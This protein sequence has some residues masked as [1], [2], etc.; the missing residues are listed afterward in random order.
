VLALGA[1]TVAAW[2]SMVGGGI[3]YALANGWTARLEYDHIEI[4]GTS[5]PFP[6]IALINSQHISARQWIGVVKFGVN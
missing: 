1:T 6:T 2:G 4:P 5:V 3:E